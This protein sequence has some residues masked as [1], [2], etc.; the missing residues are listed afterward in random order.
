MVHF[1][2]KGHAVKVDYAGQGIDFGDLYFKI[3]NIGV[4]VEICE[5]PGDLIRRRWGIRFCEIILNLS[6]SHFSIGKNDS[7][8]ASC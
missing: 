5:E 6:A 7:K 2:Q 1:M 4:G 8:T 3:G